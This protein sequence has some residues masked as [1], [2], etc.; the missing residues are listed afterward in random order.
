[1]KNY[2]KLQK[3]IQLRVKMNP[4]Q[5]LDEMKKIQTNLLDFL[6]NEENTEEFFQNLKIKIDEMIEHDDK[7]KIKSFFHLFTNI[8]N[9]HYR[10][11]T[12]FDKLFRIL[13][14]FKNFIKNNFSNYEIFNIFESNKRILLFLIDE[15]ILIFDE[16]IA[17]EIVLFCRYNNDKYPQYFL[18]EVKPFL[19]KNWFPKIEINMV[20]IKNEWVKEIEAEIPENFYEKRKIGENDN[21]ICK[22]IREDLIKDFI[23]YINKNNVPINSEINQSIYETNVYI[24]HSYFP[25]KLIE[26]AA[27]FGSIQIIKYLVIEG[28]ELNTS[29]CVHAIHSRNL[30]LIHYLEDN[31]INKCNKNPFQHL[32]N[33]SIQFHQNDVLH[34]FLNNFEEINDEDINNAFDLILRYYNF[35]FIQNNFSNE[36]FIILCKYDYCILANYILKNQNIDVNKTEILKSIENI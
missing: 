20:S 15:Q 3:I 17:K 36:S 32:L 16:R 24:K 28:V 31:Y 5:Y 8:A 14:I 13:I 10:G 11:T 22:L 23:V 12:F 7:Y 34:Y 27:F 30:E 33:A 9:Y 18:P 26:Y 2:R 19:N 1:M 29:I 21:K 4:Q 35:E 25:L 6:E